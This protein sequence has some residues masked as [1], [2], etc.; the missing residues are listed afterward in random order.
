MSFRQHNQKYVRKCA[1]SA[2]T[3]VLAD[4]DLTALN[5]KERAILTD[6]TF[7]LLVKYFNGRALTLLTADYLTAEAADTML[8]RNE[9]I[10]NALAMQKAVA[11]IVNALGKFFKEH[12]WEAT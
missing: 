5:D 7:R 4:I 12:D 10:S 2:A 3:H 1:L 8:E 9:E 11:H 6:I